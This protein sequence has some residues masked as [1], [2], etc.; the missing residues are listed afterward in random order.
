MSH[1]NK[2]PK[3]YQVITERFPAYI[4]AVE[5]LGKAVKAAGPLPEKTILLIQMAAAIARGSEGSAASHAKRALA[6]GASKEEIMHAIL[7]LTSTVG[8]PQ[9]AAA[10]SWL[11]E[12]EG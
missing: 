3:N 8:F 9:V 10:F 6:A 1:K 4:E 5:A 11:D 7:S 2:L 12:I